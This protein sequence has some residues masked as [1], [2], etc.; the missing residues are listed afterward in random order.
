M[1]DSGHAHGEPTE[2]GAPSADVD[3]GPDVK[4]ERLSDSRLRVT[5]GRIATEVTVERVY[6]TPRSFGEFH[7]LDHLV[8]FLRKKSEEEG[9]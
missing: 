7:S 9:E 4:I 1:D 6:R 8:A 2:T 5:V 3:Y